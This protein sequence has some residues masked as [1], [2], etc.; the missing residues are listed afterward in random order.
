M[1]NHAAVFWF[2]DTGRSVAAMWLADRAF[3]AML[4]QAGV[5]FA[6]SSSG[7]LEVTEG[8]G[9]RRGERGIGRNQTAKGQ[10]RRVIVP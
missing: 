3:G 8:I 10:K 7:A 9:S 1:A 4:G 2:G 5:A 6:K